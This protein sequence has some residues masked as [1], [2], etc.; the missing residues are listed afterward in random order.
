MAL[1]W[2]DGLDLDL[3]DKIID[4]AFAEDIGR[5][6]LTS[7][8][9][10]P[11]D[12]SFSGVMSARQ[13]MVCT[14]L[15]VAGRVFERYSDKIT[16]NAKVQDGDLVAAGSILAELTG[17]A[18]ELLTAERTAI[19]ILQHLSGIA[20]LTREYADKIADLDTI[21]LDTRKTIPVYRQLAKYATRMGGAT[22]HRMALDDGV[23]IKDNHVAISGGIAE[24]VRRAKASNLPNIEVECDTLEQVKE[25]VEAGAD[26]ILFDNMSAEMMAKAVTIVAG[27]LPTEASGDVNLTTIRAKAESGVTYISVGALTHSAPAVNIGLDWSAEIL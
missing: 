2:P 9:V 14:G 21:L 20:T 16:W 25:A 22:N 24:A 10:I 8:A 27:R 23:L 1:E 26:M 19:N 3:V 15:P 18:I 5:G 13:K 7:E 6:D 17:P 11:T 4:A 12:T